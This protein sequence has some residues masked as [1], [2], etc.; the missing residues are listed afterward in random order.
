MQLL[1]IVYRASVPPPW[2]EG[3]NIP[4]DEPGFS[5]RMLEE[6]LSQE[7]DAASRRFATIDQHVDFI[8]QRLLSGRPAQ[9]LDLGCGPGL[10]TSR[11]ARL[12]HTCT[13]ID[14]SPAS[15]DYAEKQAAR[16]S[17]PCT[18]IR[19]DLRTADFGDGY[20]LVMLIFGEL[21][22]FEPSQARSIL[23]KAFRALNSGGTL[24][25][26]PHTYDAVRRMGT[27]PQSWYSSPSGLFSDQPHLCLM[28][29]FWHVDR[30]AATTRYDIVDANTGGV[31][32]C[33]QTLQAYTDDEYRTLLVEC[34]YTDIAILPSWGDGPADPVGDFLVVCA[35]KK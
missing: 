17:L 11:L 4:W 26:E 16:E 29:H 24:L 8:H 21:N 34:G 13:G 23:E 15:I 35:R 9:L 30:R 19:Q 18:Y 12:G 6:H 27:E 3:D 20:D 2:G 1:D 5:R 31:T 33:A 10:Y 7:H 32:R 28:E 25:L 14:Y 22:V